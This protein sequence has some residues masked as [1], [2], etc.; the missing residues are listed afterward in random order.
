MQ[1]STH[2]SI[3][4]SSN[5]AGFLMAPL[6]MCLPVRYIAADWQLISCEAP[7]TSQTDADGLTNP[8]YPP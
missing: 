6:A 7:G 1:N 4:T 5:T 8:E 2:I 3:C